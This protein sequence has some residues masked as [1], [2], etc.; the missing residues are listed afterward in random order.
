[1]APGAAYDTEAVLQLAPFQDF[2]HS[3]RK[4]ALAWWGTRLPCQFFTQ[5]DVSCAAGQTALVLQPPMLLWLCCNGKCM[6]HSL[7]NDLNAVFYC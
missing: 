6:L 2:S 7:L 1:M 5:A 4:M 3:R